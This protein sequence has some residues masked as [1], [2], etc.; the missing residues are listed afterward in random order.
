MRG[1]VARRGATPHRTPAQRRM[2]KATRPA[3]SLAAPS[4]NDPTRASTARASE[5]TYMAVGC[6]LACAT[7]PASL[8]QRTQL[9]RDARA[10]LAL[11]RR[12]PPRTQ[13]QRPTRPTSHPRPRPSP[14]A[15]PRVRV[16]M[17]N[18]ARAMASRAVSAHPHG[19]SASH[20]RMAHGASRGGGRARDTA[21]HTPHPAC[22]HAGLLPPHE[23]T[24]EETKPD[25]RGVALFACAAP[26]RV[27]QRTHLEGRE[28]RAPSLHYHED[29]QCTCF[30]CF[31]FMELAEIG[32]CCASVSPPQTHKGGLL[33]AASA[34]QSQCRRLITLD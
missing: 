16:R 8:Y 20:A 34:W 28:G 14:C 2:R 22:V 29:L 9:C 18:A 15:W 12:P 26:P 1:P 4:A 23:R 11:A 6:S 7:R 32:R 24:P 33:L 10:P 3:G 31:R 13:L 25:S 27:I 21:A 17:R 19:P 5:R 30:G